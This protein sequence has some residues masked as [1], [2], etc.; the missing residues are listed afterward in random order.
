M[1]CKVTKNIFIL[2]VYFRKSVNL[3]YYLSAY[4]YV[5]FIKLQKD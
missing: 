3:S 2:Q 5:I 4:N 1:K